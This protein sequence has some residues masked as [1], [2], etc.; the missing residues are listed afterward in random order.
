MPPSI[1]VVDDDELVSSSLE[2]ALNMEGYAVRTAHSGARALQ[3]VTEA[4]PDL[5]ILDITMPGM[6]GWD[7]L[8]RLREISTVNQLPVVALT[9]N[10]PDPGEFERAGFTSCLWKGSSL[11][12]FLC[13]IRRVMDAAATS[14]VG[15][16]D[17]CAGERSVG[18]RVAHQNGDRLGLK[19]PA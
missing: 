3:I 9:G 12:R 16:V 11:D 4:K 1:L 5:I 15:W 14:P 13:T 19:K 10:E 17:S 8:K 2:L 18:H 7:A 6:T